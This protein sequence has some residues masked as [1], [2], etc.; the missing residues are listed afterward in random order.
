MKQGS[1]L[2]LKLA[3]VVLGL[4][5]LGICVFALP[6]GISSSE[7]GDY[8]PIFWGL[9]VTAL[10]FFFALYQTLLLLGYV[11]K[12]K[13]FSKLSVNALNTIK[14][15]ALVISALFLAGM[16]YIYRVAEQDDAPGA[17]V[18]GLVVAGASFAIATFAAVLQRLLRSAIDMKKEND[19]TV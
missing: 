18:L 2:I 7:A 5:V 19:L 10:P 12:N 14:Y 17:I 3:V 11:D 13:A 4:I 1:T 15:C 8:R 16:P 9:Y 6:V